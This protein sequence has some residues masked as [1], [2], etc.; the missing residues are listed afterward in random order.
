M[1]RWSNNSIIVLLISLSTLLTACESNSK[2]DI[3][4]ATM[5]ASLMYYGN[6]WVEIA[7]EE[8]GATCINKA[9]SSALVYDFA[10]KLWQGNYASE[11][12]L[13]MIDILLIQFANCKDVCGLESTMLPTADDYT[14][15]FSLS[16]LGNPFRQYSNAQCMDYILKKWQQ[17][18]IKNNRPM[19]VLLVTHWH[20]SRTTY[21]DAVRR[22]A[23][24]WNIEVV[25]LDKNI[26]FTKEVLD[27]DGRQPS[28]K[29]AT[30]TEVI[31]GV[32]YGWHPLRGSKGDYIQHKMGSILYEKLKTYTSEQL[33]Q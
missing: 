25:E 17:I 1:E 10:Y 29:Y 7:C 33:I 26:G 3:V 13:Q 8:L 30:D 6:G 20:D 14:A 5:G 11:K 16:E 28:L 32:T 23:E 24:R 4:V 21:N 19:H 27:P 2:S 31:D 22:L 18:C 9:V 12:E 15:P